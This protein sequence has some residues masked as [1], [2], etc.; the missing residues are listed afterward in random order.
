MHRKIHATVTVR[1]MRLSKPS[2]SKS[3]D[4]DSV[5]GLQPSGADSQPTST[6]AAAA[7]NQMST[8]SQA[9]P[10]REIPLAVVPLRTSPRLAARAKPSSTSSKKKTTNKTKK[11]NRVREGSLPPGLA[12][13]TNQR[14]DNFF[15][16]TDEFGINSVTKVTDADGKE[17]NLLTTD[18][19]VA[20]LQKLASNVGVKNHHHTKKEVIC[21]L[22]AKKLFDKDLMEKTGMP[23]GGENMQKLHNSI[24]QSNVHSKYYLPFICTCLENTVN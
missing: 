10:R 8:P 13:I 14:K 4:E 3:E 2:D 6:I 5:L 12:N 7:L 21:Q 16:V 22:I 18:L 20:Q 19:K 23:S 15:I 1:Q 11:Q 9:P 17:Y 24:V